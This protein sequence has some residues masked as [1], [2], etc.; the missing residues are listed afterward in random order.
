MQ[1]QLSQRAA[2]LALIFAGL[3]CARNTAS[4]DRAAAAIDTTTANQTESGVTDSSGQ[5]T[6]GPGVERTRADQG[7][8][9]T[10]KGDT[11]NMGVDSATGQARGAQDSNGTGQADSVAANQTESGVTDS[12]GQSTL[13]PEVEKTRPDQGQPVNSKGDTVNMGV[14]SS[15]TAR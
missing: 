13:G 3:A 10:S 14:D 5:S 9:V 15:A 7:Q 11:I 1:V 6:L 12:S 4:D 2:T 8:P